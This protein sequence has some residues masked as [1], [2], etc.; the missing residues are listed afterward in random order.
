MV[1][2]RED[3][4][5]QKLLKAG[6]ILKGLRSSKGGGLGCIGGGVTLALFGLL[7]FLLLGPFFLCLFGVPGVI[8]ILVGLR[9]KHKRDSS[10]LSYYQKQTGFSEGELR[11]VDREL[12]AP[13]VHIIGYIKAGAVNEHGIACFITE[14]YFVTEGYYVRRLEDMI[15]AA[16][17]DRMV[18]DGEHVIFGL[19]CLSKQDKEVCFMT[20]GAASDKKEELCLEIIEEL[21]R[22]NPKLL[23][24][25]YIQ[26]GDRE[27][28]LMTESREILRLYQEGRRLEEASQTYR[29]K[30]V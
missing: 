9:L 6:S 26:C 4:E 11:S 23:C 14:H 16:Y 8:L 24:Q 19:L 29:A 13:N 18:P 10:Y 7:L 3:K 12:A 30:L 28:E 27:Y 17:T 25:E 15:A 1:I 21:A 2:A 22:R 20:F 5:Y